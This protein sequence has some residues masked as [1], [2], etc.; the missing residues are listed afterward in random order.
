MYTW[1]T[2]VSTAVPTA[3]IFLLPWQLWSKH[4]AIRTANEEGQPAKGWG[5]TCGQEGGTCHLNPVSTNCQQLSTCQRTACQ[6]C[7]EWPAWQAD[8]GV[9]KSPQENVQEWG[10]E[11]QWGIGYGR[12]PWWPFWE[13]IQR[14]LGSISILLI[15]KG[16]PTNKGGATQW[17]LVSWTMSREIPTVTINHESQVN[18]LDFAVHGP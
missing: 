3:V 5:L 9:P 17:V 6:C 4:H 15:F 11:Q 13:Q 7:Q 2:V 14:R 12:I 18:D 1:T 10:L 8:W 16:L